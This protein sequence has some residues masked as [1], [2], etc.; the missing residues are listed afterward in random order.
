MFAAVDCTGHGVPGAFMSIVGNHQLNYSVNVNGARLASDILDKLNE[1]VTKSLHQKKEGSSVKDGMDIS[2]ISI[3]KEK[4]ALDFAGAYNPLY[5][6]RDG[7]IQ[8]FR[9]DKFPIGAFLGEKLK[10]FTN[11]RIET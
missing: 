4:M 3:E 10:Q 5:L 1:G 2:L 6:V 9:G 7:E 8:I 11:H